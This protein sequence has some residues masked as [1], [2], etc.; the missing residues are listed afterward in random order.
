[1]R[2]SINRYL[3]F[4]LCTTSVFCLV[5]LI[6]GSGAEPRISVQESA[7]W[8]TS[9]SPDTEDKLQQSEPVLMAQTHLEADKQRIINESTQLNQQVT[10]L[11][12][13][14]RFSEAIPTAHRAL[15]LLE[16]AFGKDHPS[17]TMPLNQ[18]A[19]LYT[20]QRLYTKAEPL[21]QRALSIQEKALGP[22][23]P[24]VAINLYNLAR[25]YGSERRYAEAEPLY[26]RAL[27]I[28]EKATGPE[29]LNVARILDSLAVLYNSQRR[30][31]EAESQ[32]QRSL[33]IKEKALGTKHPT[34]AT[35]LNNLALSYNSQR[36]FVEAESLYQRALSIQET[37]LGTEHPDVATSLNNL[38]GLY[39]AQGLYT[40][41]VPLFQ[42]SLSILEKTVGQEHSNVASLLDSLAR[43]YDSQGLH[44]KAE[45]L[46]QRA[47]SIQEKILGAEHPSVST[48]LN[49]LALSY[50]YQRLY[51]KAE[52]LYQRALSIQEKAVGADHSDLATSLNNLAGLYDSQ[53]RFA[54]A[55][56]LYQRALSIKE[57]VLGAEHPD[58]ATI[59]SNLAGLHQSQGNH[60]LTH[61]FLSRAAEIEERNLDLM[62]STGSESRKRVYVASLSGTTN[63]MLSFSLNDA[64]ESFPAAKLALNTILRRKGR[65]LASLTDSFGTLRQNLAPVDRSLLDQLQALRSQRA[66]LTFR[67]P[68]KLSPKQHQAT[69]NQLKTQE[70]KLENQLARKSVE[71]R[72]ETQPVTLSAIQKLIPQGAALV[73][74]VKYKPFNSKAI[75]QEPKWGAPHYA[76]YILNADGDLQKVNLGAAQPIDQ[77]VAQ[78]R[79]AL[80][81]SSSKIQPI[82]RKLDQQLMEPIR[83]KL[84][85]TKQLLLSPDS[86]LNLIPFAALVDENNQ[87]LVENYDITYLSSGRDLLKLQPTGQ[88]NKKLQAPVIIANPD[89]DTLEG[90]SIAKSPAQVKNR[91]SRDLNLNF[92]P[93]PGTQ[94]EATQLQKLLGVTPLTQSKATETALKQVQ[95]PEILH[96]ATHGFFLETDFEAAAPSTDNRSGIKVVSK[97]RPPQKQ[98]NYENSLLRSGLALAGANRRNSGTEDG[99][100][101]ALEATNLNLS[102][103]KLVVLS[104]CE[105]GLGNVEN[106]EGVYGL[107]RAF[108]MAGAESQVLSLWKVDDTGTKDLMVKYYR[109]LLNKQG[110]GK[111]LHQTQLEMLNSQQYAHPYYWAAFIPSG[112]W[113]P[114][115]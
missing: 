3:L 36:R 90:T 4:L 45:P 89:Y 56:P 20:S 27:S 7:H 60:T 95:S 63:A 112:D 48:S 110:R 98:R 57:K 91:S 2:L 73:E 43:L 86:Q 12:Q 79:Q 19:I 11:F 9:L 69:L 83:D 37:E 17:V 102:G 8:R 65:V 5:P 22:E 78:F 55:E 32:Y 24:Y 107:R 114:L 49:S 101:T 18:L 113:N 82:A 31:E 46:Y 84:G 44:S 106:G 68:E 6:G 109:R 59:L 97:N 26:L 15:R 34:V 35:S 85:N 71:F 58:V 64:P 52:P 61:Q 94:A 70:E 67:T 77:T 81:S 104:A 38:A 29:H 28:Q 13:Q 54:K 80:K 76:A 14:G 16:K 105:T 99:I 53:G 103:T 100:F 88:N 66:T 75:N 39:Y 72:V 47:L 40:K 96:I 42:R 25:L 115:D 93:L 108:V 92:G 33:N 74:L 1:M 41:A 30:Y 51:E 111:A 62:L 50:N 87:Y 21:Y 10:E 23:H